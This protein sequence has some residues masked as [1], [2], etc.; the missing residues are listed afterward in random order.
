MQSRLFAGCLAIIFCAL[1]IAPSSRAVETTTADGARYTGAIVDGKRHGQGKLEWPNGSVYEGEFSN[2]LMHGRG[3]MKLPSGDRYEGSFKLGMMDGIGRMDMIDGSVYTGEYARDLFNGKGRLARA[4]GGVYEGFFKDAYQHGKGKYTEKG[5]TYEGDFLLGQYSGNGVEISKDR[6]TYRGTF[7]QG[8]YHGKGRMESPEGESFEGDFVEGEFIGNGTLSRKDGTKYNGQFVKWRMQGK[9]V[10][11][12][13]A[14]TTYEGNFVDGMPE[15]KIVMRGKNGLRY[16]GGSKD[17]RMHGDGEFRSSDGDVYK[18]SFARGLYEGQGTLTYAKP[19]PDGTKVESGVW[20]YGRLYNEAAEESAKQ[21]L[22]AAL[23]KQRQLLDSAFAG[24]VPRTVDKINMYQLLIAGD[25]AQEVFRREVE[26]VRDQFAQQFGLKGRS[27]ALI[28]S[29]NTLDKAPMATVTSIEESLRAIAAK[30]DK[31]KDILFLFLTSHGS[32]EHEFSLTQNKMQLRDLT[33]KAL[34]EMVKKS[35]IRHKVI[36]ISA[37]YGGGFIDNV[38]D[39][40]T[41]VITAARH[42]RQSFGCADENDFTYFGRAFFKESLPKSRSFHDAFR[43]AEKLIK[44]WETKEIRQTR[45]SKKDSEEDYSIPQIV[46]TA[47]IEQHLREWW[48]QV[49]R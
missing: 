36:V 41:L 35:G 30:M 32:K 38:K 3:R 44:D 13:G 7:K 23:Y 29:R 4:E 42:D 5:Y 21:Q 28:N 19:Q 24:L 15:G 11:D 6:G 18:G 9:G 17:W 37:C 46:S 14:G 10:Y 43:S 8:R 12:D 1:L 25:G 45:K 48:G 33:N 16:E 20:R 27:I 2:G 47:A 49:K 31:E 40:T 22:E 39:D 26:F 34:G